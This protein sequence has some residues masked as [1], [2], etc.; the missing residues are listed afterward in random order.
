M[1]LAVSMTCGV[2]ARACLAMCLQVSSNPPY[3]YCSCLLRWSLWITALDRSLLW[4]PYL[5]FACSVELCG[6]QLWLS[7]KLP[8]QYKVVHS[9]GTGP[10]KFFHWR[11]FSVT[12]VV[13]GC[14]QGW[15]SHTGLPWNLPAVPG[16]CAG[17]PLT[18]DG[19]SSQAHQ[20]GMNLISHSLPCQLEESYTWYKN[21]R[22]PQNKRFHGILD[23]VRF[24]KV[25]DKQHCKQL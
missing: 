9:L 11:S 5:Q 24:P 25:L 2:A 10:G 14:L 23:M 3:N 17:P 4:S 8:T 16:I 19:T 12:V 22:S 6:L 7:I 1:C 13:D 21:L 18:S 15:F 20:L